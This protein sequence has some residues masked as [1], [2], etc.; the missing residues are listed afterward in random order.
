VTKL[1]NYVSHTERIKVLYIDMALEMPS[2][3]VISK[4]CDCITPH[5]TTFCRAVL[6]HRLAFAH[7]KVTAEPIYLVFL[8]L[9]I[10]QDKHKSERGE[11]QG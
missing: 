4:C 3:E 9:A 7:L 5:G 8:C 6:Y 10:K 11:Q 1:Q 2:F